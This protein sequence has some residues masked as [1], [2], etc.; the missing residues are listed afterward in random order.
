M[1]TK[2]QQLI[3]RCADA[4]LGSFDQSQ[5]QIARRKIDAVIVTRDLPCRRQ[6]HDSR[7]VGELARLG[8]VVVMKPNRASEFLNRILGAGEKMPAVRGAG[9]GVAREKFFILGVRQCSAVVGI[10]T[11]GEHGKLV[12]DIEGKRTQRAH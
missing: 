12:A 8:I 5:T 2:E 1:K 6:E 7:G 10:E 4:R 9:P 3:D 11:Y